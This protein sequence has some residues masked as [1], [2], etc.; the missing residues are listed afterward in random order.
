MFSF[1]KKVWRDRRGNALVIAGAALPLIVGS[2]GLA[3]DTI[4][5][6]L[7]KR[8]LQRAADSAALAGAR[9]ELDSRAVDDCSTFNSASA[10]SSKPV[11]YDI[12]KNDH[13][14][15]TTACTASNP[16]SSG[17]YKSDG[18]AVQVSLTGSR[19]LSFSGM[20]MSSPPSITA[21]ATA[22][23]VDTGKFCLVTLNKTSTPGITMGGSS[24]ANLGCG[25]ISNSTGTSSI[26]T[27]GNA[28]TFT[29]DPVA[30]VGGMPASITGSTNLEPYHSPEP[31]PFA[32]KYSTSIPPG[33]TCKTFNQNGYTTTTGSGKDKVTV[34]HL[35]SYETKPG[36]GGTCY[37]DFSPSGNGTYFLDAGTYYLD[38][39]NFNPG[40]GT[41]LIGSNVTIILTGTTPG[42]V[43]LNGNTTIQLSANPTGAYAKMLFLQ[44]PGATAAS[45]FNG[46]NSSYFDGA[47]Y[48]PSTNVTFNGTSGAST[49]CAM[50]VSWTATFSGNT[51]LQNSLTRPDGT[52]CQDNTTVTAKTVALVE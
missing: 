2:A 11:A 29:A 15:I 9:A 20:F 28:Y 31:D 40:G 21:S 8:Q 12:H 10:D 16:P 35:Y 46:T 23:I 24:S 22:T 3:T 45:T 4:E 50:V 36:G 33:T 32:G 48:F 5:W 1:L 25:A 13:S 39:T 43:T 26:T 37:S 49:Q 30:S 52:P 17:S 38:S 18:N 47:M 42:A 27:N 44:A 41:T 51:N 34:N 6:S 14:G 19:A 7:W